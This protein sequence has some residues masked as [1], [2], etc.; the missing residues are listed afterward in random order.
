MTMSLG[1]WKGI[2]ESLSD[3]SRDRKS[4]RSNGDEAD[5]FGH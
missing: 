5:C 2:P 1:V 3:A 4:E